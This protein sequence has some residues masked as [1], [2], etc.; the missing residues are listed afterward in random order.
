[1]S[2]A[3][4]VHVTGGPEVLMLDEDEVGA[5]A[6]GEVQLRHTEIGLNYIDVYDRTG[7]YPMALP[8]G[9]GREAA[10]VVVALGRKVKGLRKGDR[11][12]YV[13]PQPGA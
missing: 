9:L 5:P 3:I 1:M 11:G 7:L 2:K 4:R 10:G 8:G 13:H 6:V 12:A